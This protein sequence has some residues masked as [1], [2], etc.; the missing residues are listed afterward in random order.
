MFYFLEIA[1]CQPSGPKFHEA[2][3]MEN[4]LDP[5]YRGRNIEMCN[6]IADYHRLQLYYAHRLS[7]RNL[8]VEVP[9]F[10]DPTKYHRMPDK[11]DEFFDIYKS[12][13]PIKFSAFG[14]KKWFIVELLFFLLLCLLACIVLI[15]WCAS[16][17]PLTNKYLFLTLVY[18]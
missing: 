6:F 1:I 15:W 14:I 2:K 4:R 3:H 8:T 9:D 18:I 10:F 7:H 12:Y 5:H 17:L 11:F 13:C 16:V